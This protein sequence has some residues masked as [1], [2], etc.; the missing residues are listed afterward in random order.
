MVEDIIKAVN[1]SFVYVSKADFDTM[2]QSCKEKLLTCCFHNKGKFEAF[3]DCRI[4]EEDQ[5]VS[6]L[7]VC[8]E[9]GTVFLGFIGVENPKGI[10]MYPQKIYSGERLVFEEDTILFHDI[11]YDCFIECYGNLYVIGTIKG[12]ID[13]HYKSCICCA[14]QF[15]HSRI[16]IFD[17]EFHELTSF[18]GATLYYENNQIKKEEKIWDVALESPLEKVG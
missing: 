8:D 9:V 13:F 6:L 4:C 2:I 11:P 14:S 17:S 3:F 12:C 15:Y 16:R 7:D 5:L 18:S 10:Q 1:H